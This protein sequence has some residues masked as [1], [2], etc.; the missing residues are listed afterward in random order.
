[1]K[2]LALTTHVTTDYPEEPLLKIAINLGM[3]DANLIGG[4]ELHAPENYIVYLNGQPVG[5]HTDPQ[6]FVRN[7]RLL[8]RGGKIQ[9][10]VSIYI[11]EHQ[12]AI[13]IASDGGRLVRPLIIVRRGKPLIN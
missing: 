6:R 12:N 13:Y 8:R 5:V 11:N 4:C 3:E 7:F 2:N 10:F 1:M 9:E